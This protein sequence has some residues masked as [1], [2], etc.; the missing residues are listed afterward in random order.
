MLSLALERGHRAASLVKKLR[1]CAV[2]PAEKTSV[3]LE[4]N[5]RGHR[6]ASAIENSTL[7]SISCHYVALVSLCWVL[8]VISAF[9]GKPVNLSLTR[10]PN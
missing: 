4:I 7:T 2:T 9:C 10:A 8:Q 1:I 3:L 5:E 6:A